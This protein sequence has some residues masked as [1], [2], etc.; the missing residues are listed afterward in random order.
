M[1]SCTHNLKNIFPDPSRLIICYRVSVFVIYYVKQII[2]IKQKILT[3]H[4]YAYQDGY[5]WIYAYDL[6]LGASTS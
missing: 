2:V 1:K 4:V 6:D 3:M 5:T